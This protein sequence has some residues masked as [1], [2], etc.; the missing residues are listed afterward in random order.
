MDGGWCRGDC[1]GCLAMFEEGVQV[2][3][4]QAEGEHCGKE[5]G[6]G[7][8]EEGGG[9]EAGAALGVEHG[10]GC[11]QRAAGQ[12]A[13]GNED[14]GSA[15]AGDRAAEEFQLGGA[16]EAGVEVFAVKLLGLLSC[17]DGG[18]LGGTA[19]K[20]VADLLMVEVLG[21][22]HRESLWALLWRLRMLLRAR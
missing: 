16:D 20:E 5:Q 7:G 15:E 1:Y 4:V 17:S 14:G 22:V 8:P 11:A 9:E 18:S 19:E 13:V 12:S 21:G 3:V 10:A 2:G 6:S